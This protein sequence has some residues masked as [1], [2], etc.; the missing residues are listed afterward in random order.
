MRF[1]ERRKILRRWN[2]GCSTSCN[3]WLL[4]VGRC[5]LVAVVLVAVVSW[6]HVLAAGKPVATNRIARNFVNHGIVML[7]IRD[8]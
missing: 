8:L 6:N 5:G 1:K 7:S 3:R 4:W 2:A